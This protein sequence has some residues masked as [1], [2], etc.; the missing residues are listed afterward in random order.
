[1]ARGLSNKKRASLGIAE[2][3]REIP[4]PFG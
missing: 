4:N 3:L 1:V 2:Q